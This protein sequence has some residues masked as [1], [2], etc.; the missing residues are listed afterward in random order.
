MF[1]ATEKK[2]RKRMIPIFLC[3]TGQW[4]KLIVYE[5]DFKTSTLMARKEASVKDICN[6][7]TNRYIQCTIDIDHNKH[8]VYIKTV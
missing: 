8:H 6:C 4:F 1:A 3:Y 7:M 5:K 2:I